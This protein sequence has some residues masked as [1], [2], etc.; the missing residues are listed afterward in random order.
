[1]FA[2]ILKEDRDELL[3]KQVRGVI[4]L[5]QKYCEPYD[6]LFPAYKRMLD[7]MGIPVLRVTETGSDAE[8]AALTIETF[9]ELL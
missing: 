4:F 3:Q 7:E 6:Y 1:M 5:T 8:N 9:A 2:R